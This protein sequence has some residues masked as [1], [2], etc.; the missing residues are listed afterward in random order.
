M[1]DIKGRYKLTGRQWTEDEEIM[2]FCMREDGLPY[3]VIASELYRSID[4]CEKKYRGT[5]WTS[6]PYFDPV[7]GKIAE[8]CKKAYLEKLTQIQDK[9]SKMKRMASD[10]IADRISQSFTSLPKVT[11]PVYVKNTAKREKVT[12]QEDVGLMLSDAHIGQDISLEE[13]GGLAEYNL[14]V[15]LKRVETL[16]FATS[17]IVELHSHLYKMPTLHIFC[18]GD[19]VAGMNDVGAWSPTYINLS[20]FEQFTEGVNA[21]ANMIYYWLGLFD[22][23]KFYG[24]MGN[25]GRCSAKG[26]EKEYV[27]W[28]FLVYQFLRTRFTD[29][30]RISFVTPKTWWIFEKIRSHKFLIVHGDDMKG[31]AWPAKSLLDYESKMIGVIKD[32]PDYTIAGHYHNSSEMST[33]HGRVLLNGSFIGGDI[34]SLKSLQRSSRPEQ[35]IFGI[36]D[37]RGITWRYNLDLSIDRR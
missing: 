17:D 15:F 34:Y 27:N 1:P 28:D 14:S 3:N 21:L 29:N 13:T 10:V 12:S 5:L 22:K 37:K 30:D 20:I 36:H 35:T 7:K 26:T 6:K 19:I 2:L 11:P 23:I 16:K 25:H 4:S 18:L 33:N 8:R 32:I 31:G 24:V 9:R